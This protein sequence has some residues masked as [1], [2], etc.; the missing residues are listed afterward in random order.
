M[1]LKDLPTYFRT[2][3]EA[4]VRLAVA[5]FFLDLAFSRKSCRL[6]TTFRYSLDT[7]S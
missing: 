1:A 2:D 7:K 3:S 5:K 6:K 4:E